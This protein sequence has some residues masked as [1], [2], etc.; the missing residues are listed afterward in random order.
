[1]IDFLNSQTAGKLFHGSDLSGLSQAED[2]LCAF[3]KV[4]KSYDNYSRWLEVFLS[5]TLCN[6]PDH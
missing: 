5:L 1:M 2:L 3:L 4:V 6:K